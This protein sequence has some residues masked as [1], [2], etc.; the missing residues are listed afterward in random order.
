MRGL[1]QDVRFGLRRLAR[2]PG[3]TAAAMLTLAL[4]LGATSTVAGL[5]DATLFRRPDL[6]RPAEL[7]RLYGSGPGQGRYSTLSYP[8]YADLR[9]GLLPLADL[10]VHQTT[11]AALGPPESP[12]ALTL[13]LVSGNYFETLGVTPALGRLLRP[14]DDVLPTGRAVVVVSQRLWRGPLAG[15]ASVL[16]ST[17]LL[18]GHAFEIVG[19]APVSFRGSFEAMGADAWVPVTTQDRVRPRGLGLDERGWGW[20]F[21]TGRRH[22]GIPAPALE[23]GVARLVASM[24]ADG[25]LPDQEEFQLAGASPLPDEIRGDGQRSLSLVVAAVVALLVGASANL[26][27][28][29]YARGAAREREI[30]TRQSMGASPSRLLRQL[31][32][33]NL[34][35][36]LLGAAAGLLLAALAGSLLP[37][38]LPPSLAELTADL[39]VDARLLGIAFTA[40]TLTALLSGLQPARRAAGGSPMDVLRG[41]AAELRSRGQSVTVGLQATVS[42]A[43]LVVSGLLLHSLARSR[44]YDPGFAVDEVALVAF[45][46]RR[47]GY[48][49]ARGRAFHAALE[50]RLRALPGVGSAALATMIPL[51]DTE[52]VHSFRVPGHTPPKGREGFPVNVNVVGTDYFRTLGIAI[53]EGRGFAAE[54]ARPGAGTIVVSEAFAR[55][56]WPGAS[57]LGRVIEPLEGAPLTIIGVA[58]DVP[59]GRLGEPPRAMLYANI[60]ARY[61]PWVTLAVRARETPAGLLPALRR[62]LSE[63]DPRLVP[64]AAQTLAALRSDALLPARSLGFVA[65]GFGAIS[66]ALAAS[67]LF[68]LLS[69]A[70]RRRRR[71]IGIRI[72]LGAASADVVRVFLSRLLRPV[73]GGAVLGS[74]LG[75]GGGRAVGSLLFGVGPLDAVAHAGALLLLGLV[76]LV[77]AAGPARS[78]LRVDPADV[79]RAE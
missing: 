26:A 42:V 46:L 32:T 69:Y 55:R 54:D 61:R 52:D 27:G 24:R 28:L 67:G 71:E 51:G 19:V 13:E 2:E 78:A 59:Y 77:A 37:T 72:A 49:E 70:V 4:G 33:E 10:A 9:D 53:R 75:V 45:D 44:A 73:L 8:N 40:A 48:D 14:D 47:H 39:R 50:Q 36:S 68:G 74:L 60:G 76:A 21:A 6:P 5:A 43:L 35:L 17:L 65:G 79:L 57:A 25:R 56:F 62:V 29:L 41:G 63:A 20:L 58:R 16:G 7:F 31:M 38:L 3:F 34:L 66:L 15:S 64:G 22:A 18:S 11:R 1:V 30:A 23:A 12:Q